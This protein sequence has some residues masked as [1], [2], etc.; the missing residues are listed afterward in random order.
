MATTS[1]LNNLTWR[2]A[3]LVHSHASFWLGSAFETTQG[4]TNFY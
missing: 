2:L 4:R 1:S 3:S